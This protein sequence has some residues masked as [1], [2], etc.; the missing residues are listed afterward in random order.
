M[1]VL[2]HP[3]PVP[4]FVVRG[5]GVDVG[6]AEPECLV[7]QDR[8]LARRGGDRLRL[9]GPGSE[10]AIERAVVRIGRRVGAQFESKK[11]TARMLVNRVRRSAHSGRS[12][13]R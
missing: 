6:H 7:E 12:Q 2:D 11:S 1:E 8:E 10:P 9:P 4:L 3:L 5:A 13:G